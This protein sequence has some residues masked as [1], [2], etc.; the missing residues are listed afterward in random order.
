[1]AVREQVSIKLT[2]RRATTWL[3]KW[4]AQGAQGG[5][6]VLLSGDLGAGKTF[7]ARS[8]ARNLGVPPEVRVT[9]PTFTLVHHFP[10][11]PPVVHA[12]LYRIGDPSEVDQLALREARADGAIVMVEWGEPYLREL[13]GDAAIVH[14]AL[15]A[16][17]RLAQLRST[18]SRSAQW[19]ARSLPDNLKRVEL[20]HHVD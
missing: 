9:S 3:A 1:M 11:S 10:T 14:L 20:H 16:D 5:D 12:D 15:T 2:T 18:G 8:M 17:G 6:L 19:L 7:L 4:L 13:G